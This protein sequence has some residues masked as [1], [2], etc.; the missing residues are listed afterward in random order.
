MAVLAVVE[1]LELE[2]LVQLE[3]TMEVLEVMVGQ[4]LVAEELEQLVEL[5]V[6]VPVQMVV[7]VELV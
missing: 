6:M 3:E 7:L 4:Q 2:V 1:E 5:P